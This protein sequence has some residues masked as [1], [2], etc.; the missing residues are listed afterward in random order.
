WQG[1]LRNKAKDGRFI[2]LNTTIIPFLDENGIPYQYIAIQNDITKTKEVEASLEVAMRND[3]RQTV[4]HL[5]NIIFKYEV[6]DPLSIEFTMVEG[7]FLDK[8]GIKTIDLN[9]F[10]LLKKFKK[11]QRF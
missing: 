2:W 10:S 6:K 4:K 8:L 5:Q 7:Q 1:N 11:Q 9:G 3:F